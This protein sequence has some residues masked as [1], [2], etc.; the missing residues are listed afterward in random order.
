MKHADAP[1]DA[2]W[3]AHLLRL[4]LL[5]TGSLYPKADRAIRDLLRPRS[6]LVRQQT[7]VGL[8][9]QSLLTRL[10]GKPLSLPRLRQLPPDTV[11]ALVAFPA[12]RPSIQRSLTVLR[13]LDEQRAVVEQAVRAQ[14]RQAPGYALLQTGTGL[15]PILALTIR[16]EAGDMRR[17]P[18]VGQF[19]AYCRC[20]GRQPLSNGK[21]P[22]AGNTQTGN[23]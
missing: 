14:S 21:R 16:L 9:L 22:G 10:T 23:K 19:A 18:T 2:R 6:H 7:M 3:L 11:S 1:A 8:S 20:V 5:P 13:C 17:F 15:G 12:Q 4:G